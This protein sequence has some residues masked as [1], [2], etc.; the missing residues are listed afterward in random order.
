[1]EHPEVA[2]LKLMDHPK[3]DRQQ[4]VEEAGAVAAFDRDGPGMRTLPYFKG[5]PKY[6]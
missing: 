3:V 2:T 6:T 5:T 4:V 1:M